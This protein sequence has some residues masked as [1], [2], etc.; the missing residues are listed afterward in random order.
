MEKLEHTNKRLLFFSF[1]VVALLVAAALATLWLYGGTLT[2]AKWNVFVFTRLPVGRVGN[3]YIRAS[4]V[5]LYKFAEDGEKSTAVSVF[6]NSKKVEA[7]AK[8][9]VIFTNQVLNETA[10]RLAVGDPTYAMLVKKVGA[11]VAEQTEARK[12]LYEVKLRIWYAQ[13]P[14]LEPL[15]ASR[16]QEIEQRIQKGETLESLAKA[17]SE[18]SATKWFSGD[19]GYV[20]ISGA[21]PEYKKVVESLPLHKIARV[22]TRFG[23]H[24]VQVTGEVQDHGKK[25]LHIQEIV[26]RPTNFDSW[27]ST[28]EDLVPVVWY[29]K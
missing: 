20:D 22:Y 29:V 24:I 15:L 16:A 4:E 23:L 11:Y 3:L 7:V 1:L 2:Q 9:K 28:Q 17:F 5:D 18:D 26:L 14:S 25:M 12:Y 13:Q 8:G 10:S 19:A 21:V 27:L 6:A